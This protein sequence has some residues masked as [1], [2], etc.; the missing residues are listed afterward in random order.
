MSQEKLLHGIDF[1]GY[2]WRFVV[3]MADHIWIEIY[4]PNA[5]EWIMM[6]A[7]DM[8]FGKH[9]GQWVDWGKRKGSPL[10]YTVD[11]KL[12]FQNKTH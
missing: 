5:N 6:E 11:G 3:C 10:I 1:T 4:S 8:H 12:S 9:K 2:K 7:S